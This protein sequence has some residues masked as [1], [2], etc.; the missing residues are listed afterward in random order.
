MQTLSNKKRSQ[1]LAGFDWT[2]CILSV[3][4]AIFGIIAIYSATRSMPGS[5]LSK[6]LVQSGSFVVGFGI[7]ILLSFFDYEQFEV[8]T[9]YIY[10]FCILMLAVVLIP[11]VG[12]SGE[13]GARSWIRIGPVGIQ[14]AELVKIGFIITFANFLEK[15]SDEINHPKNVLKALVHIGILA[16]LIM[17]Q[18]DTGST[19][20]LIFIFMCMIFSA[21]LSFKYILPAV[22]AGLASLPLIYF[23]V[24]DK[25]QK[26]RIMVFLDPERDPLNTGY[27]VIQS[28]IA[29]GSGQL[30]GK[31]Y[32]QGIQNQMG[33]LPTKHTD[34]I[35]STIAEEFGFIGAALLVVVL[36]MIIYKCIRTG[37]RADT[38]FGRY[39]C[40]G[41]AAMFIFHTFENIG[42]CIGLMPVTGIPL[43]FISYG[44]SSLLTNMLAIGLVLSV[45][46]RSRDTLF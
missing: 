8:L 40:V 16:G 15:K 2:L 36:F 28:K 14:P 45:S 39:I 43:P 9:K 12:K 31:G 37:Q 30:F 3:V 22:G 19:L 38:P 24:L 10:L 23:F 27:N 25:F 17:C 21:G 41:A 32:L 6:V 29:V 13:W 11:G 7:M 35:F 20:V 5:S 34:F 44:G 33:H 26:D 1:A 4:A 18:P 46:Y 42:M